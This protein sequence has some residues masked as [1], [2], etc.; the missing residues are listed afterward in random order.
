MGREGHGPLIRGY[1]TWLNREVKSPRSGKRV[2]WRRLIEEQVVA[3]GRHCRGD[4]PYRPYVM[5]Y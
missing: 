4:E 2:Q 5:D 1:E 3:Y